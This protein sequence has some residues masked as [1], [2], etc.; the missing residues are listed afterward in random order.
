MRIVAV[1]GL[2]RPEMDSRE[3]G[4]SAIDLLR[5]AIDASGLSTRKWAEQVAW[6][7]ER[8]VRRWLAGRAIPAA[9]VRELRRRLME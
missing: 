9:V 4:D 6:R 2:V 3:S 1:F 7:D 5:S 8:T